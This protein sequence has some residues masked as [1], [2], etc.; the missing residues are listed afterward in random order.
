MNLPY[1]EVV[2]D[3]VFKGVFDAGLTADIALRPED[4]ADRRMVLALL[5]VQYSDQWNETLRNFVDGG[6]PS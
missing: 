3:R 6:G 1:C 2:T 5:K 4:I